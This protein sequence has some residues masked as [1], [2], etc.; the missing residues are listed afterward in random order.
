MTKNTK[1]AMIGINIFDRKYNG[2]EEQVIR[3]QSTKSRMRDIPQD[4]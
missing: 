4:E 2:L 1:I 3:N